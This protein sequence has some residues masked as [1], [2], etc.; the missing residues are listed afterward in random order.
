MPLRVLGSAFLCALTLFAQ[1]YRAKVQGV[2][3][4]ASDASVPGAKITL[5]NIATGISATRLSG[6]AGNYLFDNVEP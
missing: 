1:D 3:T 6:P 5:T 4:D 2:V